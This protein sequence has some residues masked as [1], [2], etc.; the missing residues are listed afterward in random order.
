V[1]K[2]A[3]A[4]ATPGVEGAIDTDA[5]AIL[6]IATF[7]GLLIRWQLDPDAMQ[8]A[9]RL[10][11]ALDAALAPLVRSADAHRAAAT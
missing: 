3:F 5:L 1:T 11:S 10:I 8:D 6:I 2:Q 4:R 7:D 9:S